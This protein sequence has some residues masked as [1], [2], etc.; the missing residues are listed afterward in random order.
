ML[1]PAR[2]TVLHNGILVQNNEAPF[3]PTSWLKWLPYE[4]QGSR[5]PI[6]LQDHDHPVKY[7]NIWLRELPERAAPTSDDL[8]R[9]ATIPLAPEVLDQFVGQYL[10]NDKPNA[11][12]ATIERKGDHLTVT[13]PFRPQSLALEPISETEFD[14]PF[15]DG[16][17]T[18]R[19]DD[20]GRVI[21]ARFR[22][23][24]G[25]RDMKKL[26]P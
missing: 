7:R 10:L 20:Q 9:E 21:G 23:G 12:R 16:R 11:P 13:F 22:V 1:E 18:F 17:F 6:A 15:T 5:G 14:L 19:K 3:G 25:A 8:A 26:M 4:D 24:D 2:I